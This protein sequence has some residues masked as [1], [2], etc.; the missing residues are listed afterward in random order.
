LYV[1]PVTVAEP[2]TVLAAVTVYSPL[3]VL[4]VTVAI[5]YNPFNPV[6]PVNP[7]TVK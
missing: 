2:L 6:T 3:A 4:L 1:A 5:W 7:A